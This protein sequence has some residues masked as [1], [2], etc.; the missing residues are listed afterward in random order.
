MRCLLR[1]DGGAVTSEHA[2]LLTCIFLLLVGAVVLMRN[3][4]GELWGKVV[5]KIVESCRPTPVQN[6]ICHEGGVGIV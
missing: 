2:V 4:L 6:I 3:E 1:D 5:A